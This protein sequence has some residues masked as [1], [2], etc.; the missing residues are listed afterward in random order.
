MQIERR[1]FGA[2][3]KRIRDA[4]N[5]AQQWNQRGLR[6]N[7]N[8]RAAPHHRFDEAGEENHVSQALLT[9]QQQGL[10][11]NPGFTVPLRLWEFAQAILQFGHAPARF[12][13]GPAALKIAQRQMN[14]GLV[15]REPRRIGI[16][17]ARL[18][19][20]AD[21]ILVPVQRGQREAEIVPHHLERGIDLE[22]GFERLQLPPPGG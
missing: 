20:E 16:A 11:G 14:D 8:A 12:V 1:Q 18:L 17:P 10:T 3:R 13:I 22:R 6:F 4:G 5:G 2:V 9:V 21:G 7:Q 19:E 15:E